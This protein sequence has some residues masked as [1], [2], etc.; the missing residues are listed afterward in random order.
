MARYLHVLE[1]YSSAIQLDFPMSLRTVHTISQA[2]RAQSSRFSSVSENIA[3]LNTTGYKRSTVHFSEMM[4]GNHNQ[5]NPAAHNGGNESGASTHAATFNG[6][7]SRMARDHMG[8]GQFHQTGGDLDLAIQGSGK[9]IVR[10]YDGDDFSVAGETYLTSAGN[11]EVRPFYKGGVQSLENQGLYLSDQN[12]HNVMGLMYSEATG[13]YETVN[14]VGSLSPIRLAKAASKEATE[15][16]ATSEVVFGGNLPSDTPVGGS[17]TLGMN[18]YNGHGK[19]NAAGDGADSRFTDTIPMSFILTKLATNVWG[20]KMLNSQKVGGKNVDELAENEIPYGDEIP[21]AAVSSEAVQEQLGWRIQFDGDGQPLRVWT[22]GGNFPPAGSTVITDFNNFRVPITVTAPN[23]AQVIE[24]PNNPGQFLR[25]PALPKYVEK[26]LNLKFDFR[27]VDSYG[28]ESTVTLTP[29]G[30]TV[31]VRQFTNLSVA[32]D[33]I[34]YRH[35][36][37]GAQVPL[38]KLVAG[39]ARSIN[40][41]D[42]VSGTLSRIG[43]RSGEVSVLALDSSGS[44]R[45]LTGVLEASDVDLAEEFSEMIINQRAYSV[46]TKTLTT[47]IEM[48]ERAVQLKK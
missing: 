39:V 4:A 27:N 12:G 35:F 8:D 20:I 43:S 11:F 32:S 34:V 10:D 19:V 17:V 38:A 7:S 45:L 36:D 3:N 13:E 23:P 30:R 40:G 25:N 42:D 22:G 15:A 41:L 29:N 5:V 37:D 48:Q 2:L 31:T 1:A 24:D 21:L 9:F 14:S 44:Q 47:A 6:I 28:G 26:E 18:L 16:I 46:S 33:G